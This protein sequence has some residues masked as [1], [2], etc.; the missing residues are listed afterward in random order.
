MQDAVSSVVI[1]EKKRNNKLDKLYIPG[2][3]SDKVTPDI[4]FTSEA[5]V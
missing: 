1:I 2:A 5:V 3:L 4:N